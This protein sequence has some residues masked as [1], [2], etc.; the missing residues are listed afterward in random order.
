MGE[1]M[2][3]MR[4]LMLALMALGAYVLAKKSGII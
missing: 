4:I 1:N 3:L 2:T